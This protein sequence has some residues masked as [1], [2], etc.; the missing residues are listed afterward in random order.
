MIANHR[1]KRFMISD[2]KYGISDTSVFPD[3]FR[4]LKLSRK[5]KAPA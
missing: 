1:K 3:S 4:I 2:K 5:G